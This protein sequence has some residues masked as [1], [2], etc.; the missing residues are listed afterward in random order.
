PTAGKSTL[1]AAL[2]AAR[3]KIADY[4]FTTL[5]PNLGVVAYREYM[6]F[7]MA[8][9]P[10]I[11]EGA[12]EGRGLGLRFLKHIERNAVL[13]FM[14]PVDTEDLAHAYTI[15]LDEIAAFNSELLEKPRMLALT[16]IDLLSTEERA[17]L[18]LRIQELPSELPVF[19][20]SAVAHQGLDTLKDAL[21]RA[22]QTAKGV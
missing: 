10:G 1:I 20:I 17:A 9:I 21:W 15:L 8:D 22:I 13:L 3:P 4:P 18:A 7:V 2:S 6:S 16:K 11:I 12:H 14:I 19:P 5:E